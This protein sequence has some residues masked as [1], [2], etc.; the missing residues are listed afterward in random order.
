VIRRKRS[1]NR[2][3][4]R[5]G[6]RA[7]AA[8]AI[9]MLA[10]ALAATT[11]AAAEVNVTGTWQ[12]AYHCASGNC[13]GQEKSGV[14]VLQQAAGSSSVN[15][16]I[17][18]AGG[19]SGTVSGTVSANTLTLEGKG[20]RGYTATGIET[21]SADGLS[22]SGS[23]SDSAGTSGTLTA[24]RPSLPV[25][26]TTPGTLRPSAI[27][28]LCNLEAATSN[29]TCTA[30]VGDGSREPT[31]KIPTGTVSF[32][33][34][35]GSFSPLAK[36]QLS[37]APGTGSVASCSVSY[38]AATKIPPG[39]QPPVTGAYSGDGVFAPSA[40]KAGTGAVFSPIV[41]AASST[42]E[43]A[44]TEVKCPVAKAEGCPIGV[45]ISLYESGGGAVVARKARKITIGASKLTLKAGQSR[46]VTVSLNR[47]GKKLL[48]KHQRL[49]ALL[50][51]NWGGAAIKT[52][53]LQLKLKHGK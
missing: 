49:T 21:I 12:G 24:S 53:K 40:A 19:G 23:Y 4:S 3:S 39:T 26:E 16:T 45:E 52:Q 31:T 29:F 11:A 8:T 25:F 34:P 36:C 41:G 42:G 48:A 14:F 37:A 6:A 18:I 47:A 50:T 44:K 33:A 1:L 13:A 10:L 51:V 22:W 43:G 5:T 2:V 15:G 35:S 46:V 38:V 7:A 20:E 28:V 27:Q 17:S 30:Q 32:T 9:A